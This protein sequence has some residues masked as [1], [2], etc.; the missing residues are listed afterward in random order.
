M[1]MAFCPLKARCDGVMCGGGGLAPARR[2]VAALRPRRPVAAPPD[3]MLKK[4]NVF[5]SEFR[6]FF[7]RRRRRKNYD[8]ISSYFPSRSAAG[9]G[10]GSGGG[11]RRLAARGSV[12]GGRVL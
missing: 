11:R 3:A 6:F 7:L 2:P 9:G 5:P 8:G 10:G 1:K 4:I 12:F